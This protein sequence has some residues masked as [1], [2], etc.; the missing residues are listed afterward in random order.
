MALTTE[1][2]IIG[3]SPFSILDRRAIVRNTDGLKEYWKN[4]VGFTSQTVTANPTYWAVFTCAEIL[5]YATDEVKGRL[6]IKTN[7]DGSKEPVVYPEPLSQEQNDE[8]VRKGLCPDW[9]GLLT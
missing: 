9:T 1:R 4:D 6:Y 8:A 2:H 7:S 5:L 3:H